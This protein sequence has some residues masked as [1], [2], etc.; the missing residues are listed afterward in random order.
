MERITAHLPADDSSPRWGLADLGLLGLSV[1]NLPL[2]MFLGVAMAV[3]EAGDDSRK[4][5]KTP[6]PDDWLAQASESPEVSQKGLAHLAKCLDKK[7]YVSVS[8]A[9]E[10]ARIEQA[11]ADVASKRQQRTETL[12]GEGAKALLSRAK[13]ECPS[14]FDLDV[15]KALES[16]RTQGQSA[17]SFASGLAG[18]W[19]K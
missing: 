11:E 4:R 7:G 3:R 2:A 15:G 17:V 12:Q 10:W 8:D 5:A 18:R 1:A 19:R 16:V 6:M 13:R 9:L 14:L